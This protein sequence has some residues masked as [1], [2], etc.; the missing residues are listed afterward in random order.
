MEEKIYW[1]LHLLIAKLHVNIWETAWSNFTDCCIS[2]TKQ[3]K[4][5]LKYANGLIYGVSLYSIL[6]PSERAL[7]S[8]TG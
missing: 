2:N 1:V 4:K 5:K 3:I 7:A 6:I 8:V